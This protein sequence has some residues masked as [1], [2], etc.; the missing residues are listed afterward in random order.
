MQVSKRSFLEDQFEG[1]IITRPDRR[2][3]EQSRLGIKK[4]ASI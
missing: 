4:N 1:A 3:F 2:L